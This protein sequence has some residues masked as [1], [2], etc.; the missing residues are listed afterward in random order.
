[1]HSQMTPLPILFLEELNAQGATTRTNEQLE[2]TRSQHY[3][4]GYDRSLG[5]DWRIKAEAYYQ[6]L[7]NIPV[8]AIPSSYSVI[9]EGADFIFEERGGLVNEGTATNYGIEL[10]VEK[11]FS[12]GFYL[13]ATGSIYESQYK[14]SDG[15]ERNTAFNNQ[16]V[17]NLLAGKEWKVGKSKR[18]AVSIDT[19]I[20]SS[21]GNPYTP[22][23]LEGTRANA[24]R[25]LVFED[26]AYTLRYDDYFRWDL[27]F[28]FQLN[29]KTKKIAHKFFI[30]FQ[31]VLNRENEFVKRYNEVTD[32]INTVTQIGFFP[33]VLYRIQF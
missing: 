7:S 29:G 21:Q 22:I 8:E 3:V 27:K 4:V 25:Q 19:K 15:I 13:L 10:T 32:E 24:G 18:N 20:T 28:G 11:F 33:D 14:G 30:D 23:D 9:N 16:L 12:K 1:M 31:N 6:V 17:G 2:F 26:L 5:T